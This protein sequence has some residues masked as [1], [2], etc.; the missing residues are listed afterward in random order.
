MANRCVSGSVAKRAT[1][2]AVRSAA[3]RGCINQFDHAVHWQQGAGR[4]GR[5]RNATDR[6]SDGPTDRRQMALVSSSACIV[7]TYFLSSVRTSHRSRSDRAQQ[8]NYI[9]AATA[10]VR[11]RYAFRACRILR[12]SLQGSA[13]ARAR[14]IHTTSYLLAYSNTMNGIR[15]MRLNERHSIPR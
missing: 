6:P 15:P 4:R 10:R 13:A 9:G 11:F 8:T 14:A 2:S 12:C 5:A 1:R 3:G 7:R